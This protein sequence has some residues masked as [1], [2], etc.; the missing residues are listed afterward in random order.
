ML[1]FTHITKRIF[2][3]KYSVDLQAIATNNVK[4]ILNKSVLFNADQ[5][6]MLVLHD[7][8]SDISKILARA[9]KDAVSTDCIA[10]IDFDKTKPEDIKN[11][12]NNLKQKDLVVCVQT[13]PFHL[14]DYRLRLELFNRN[15]KNIEHVHLGLLSQNQY[16]TYINSLSFDPTVVGPLARKLKDLID[17]GS[18]FTVTSGFGDHTCTLE[19]N[20]K[21]ESALLNLGDYTGMANVGGTFPVGE[22]FSEPKELTNVNGKVLIF[23]FPNINRTMEFCENPFCLHIEHGKV[24]KISDD[25]PSSFL[26]VF[27]VVRQGEGEVVVREFGIGLNEGMGRNQPLNEV[28]AFERQRGMHLSLGKKHTV[29]KKPGIK[30]KRTK[31]HIDVFVVLN[32]IVVD[33]SHTMFDDNVFHV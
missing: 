20:T 8:R 28:T 19:Y 23:A 22:V 25:A 31:F 30:S 9:Y 27:D 29:F 4:N 17:L 15:L 21:M 32:K 26:E 11:F 33:D 14:N 6:K 1:K 3:R 7:E 2:L 12:I 24:T 13:S 16:Q 5:N 10:S 18:K